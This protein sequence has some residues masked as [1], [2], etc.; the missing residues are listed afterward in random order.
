MSLQKHKLQLIAVGKLVQ[1]LHYG[2]FAINWWTFINKDEK[3]TCVLIHLNMRVQVELNETKFIICIVNTDN[4]TNPGYVCELD[5]TGKVY[6]G[7]SEAI[8][9]TYKKL[10]NT[11][12]RY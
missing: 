8:N 11:K 10:F 9:E 2:S 4:N 5:I 7:S 6:L 12:T 3:Q 1:T